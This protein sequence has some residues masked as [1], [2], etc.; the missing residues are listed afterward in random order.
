[1]VTENSVSP[2]KK[3][4]VTNWAIPAH[5]PKLPGDAGREGTIRGQKRG[6][7]LRNHLGYFSINKHFHWLKKGF[8]SGDLES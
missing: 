6:K 1:M 8:R 7:A 5:Y 4:L 3:A 2:A